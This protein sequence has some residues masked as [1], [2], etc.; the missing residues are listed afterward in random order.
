MPP[1]HHSHSSHSSHSHSSHSSHS[2]SSHSSRSSGSSR[3]Y[4]SRPVRARTNQ[5]TG[6]STAKH[7][8]SIRYDFRD[9]DYIYYPHSWTDENGNVFR[10]GYY[11]E[12]GIHYTN[13]AA[14]NVQTTLTC[15]FCGTKSIWEWKEGTIPVCSN[16]GGQI[17]IDK[18]DAAVNYGSEKRLNKKPLLIALFVYLGINIGL[19]LT[20]A[21]IMAVVLLSSI[22]YKKLPIHKNSSTDPTTRAAVVETQKMPSSVYVKEI[23]RTCYLD[24]EDYYDEESQCWF[25]YNTDVVPGQWQYWYEGISSDYGDY[26][27]MEY[28]DDEGIWYIETSDGKW[29]KLPDKY[30]TET[31]WHFEDKNVNDLY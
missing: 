5:P 13:I 3:S 27:W 24:G 28:D 2:H 16:C 20:Y 9:H 10:E 6:W 23:N 7:G 22:I 15:Q 11:D 1:S 26:G 30:D 18:I 4:S 21:L 17:K 31:L 14:S 19:P 25:W 29:K 12:N 8:N